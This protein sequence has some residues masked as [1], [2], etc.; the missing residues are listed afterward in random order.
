MS[1]A[2]LGCVLNRQS[3]L[4]FN[5]SQEPRTGCFYL[6]QELRIR[7]ARPLSLTVVVAS[8][9]ELGAIATQ[10]THGTV[11]SVLV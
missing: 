8:L 4:V 9:P 6:P 3:K 5:F 2:L 10:P 7:E 11:V 1:A